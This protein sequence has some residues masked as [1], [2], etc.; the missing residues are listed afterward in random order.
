MRN[1]SCQM[2]AV[3][4]L[5]LLLAARASRCVLWSEWTHSSPW[6]D[7]LRFHRGSTGQ[8]GHPPSRA[9]AQLPVRSSLL[10]LPS[11]LRL[12]LL[13]SATCLCSWL[14]GSRVSPTGNTNGSIPRVGNGAASD[15]HP[16]GTLLEFSFIFYEVQQSGFL[17]AWNRRR[18][19]QPGGFRGDA[20]TRD[21]SDI[22]ID[23]VG[24]F[25]DAGGE[26]CLANTA[27]PSPRLTHSL[28]A[29]LWAHM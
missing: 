21:G 2:W 28:S 29:C 16:W 3:L 23:A 4:S 25:H 6:V 13:N 24:G 10:R 15:V 26:F 27:P 18:L 12:A 20:H 19:G 11:E 5:S 8:E 1:A 14:R 22:G 17:P 9:Q 7:S